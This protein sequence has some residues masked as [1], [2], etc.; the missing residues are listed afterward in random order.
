MKRDILLAGFS[1]L[2]LAYLQS[3]LEQCGFSVE[4]MAIPG[5]YEYFHPLQ[6]D[7]KKTIAILRDKALNVRHKKV[8]LQVL[9]LLNMQSSLSS[10][11]ERQIA[12]VFNDLLDSNLYKDSAVVYLLQQQG[13]IDTKNRRATNGFILQSLFSEWFKNA[14]LAA[15]CCL[16]EKILKIK[17]KIIGLQ[18]LTDSSMYVYRIIEEIHK[19]FPQIKII[20]GGIH[21]TALPVPILK[22]YPFVY[23]VR[24]EGEISFSELAKA[25]LQRSPIHKIPGI[26]FMKNKRLVQTQERSLIADLDALPFPKHAVAELFKLDHL[27]ILTSRGCPYHCSF[28]CLGLI[29]KNKIRYRSLENVIRELEYI[30]Q[31]FPKAR[32]IYITDDNFLINPKRVNA[33]CEEIIKRDFDFQFICSGQ[34]QNLTQEIV[35]KLE[36]A[37]FVLVDFGLETGSEKIATAMHKK[38]DKE[39]ILQ[40]IRYFA[41]TKIQIRPNL[42]VGL[43]GETTETIKETGLFVQKLQKIKR[44]SFWD[45]GIAT[46]YPGTEL[47]SKMINAGRITEAEVVDCS[48]P[49]VYTLEHT[50]KELVDLYVELLSFIDKKTI[51]VSWFLRQIHILWCQQVVRKTVRNKK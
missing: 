12:K 25:L 24:G 3:T 26:V 23:I 37:G 44:M 27:R 40:V 11:N 13:Y 34:I 46:V 7:K 28:C 16:R 20:I 2:G 1:Y 47:Y 51:T 39:K 31:Q 21:A 42:I 29:S 33:F 4:C 10:L 8:I 43:P 49:V 17:P 50:V 6:F 32:K 48:I 5:Q 14:P 19:D 41:K 36:K 9:S 38:T 18:L 45:S 22:K 35:F 30:Q 15:Y